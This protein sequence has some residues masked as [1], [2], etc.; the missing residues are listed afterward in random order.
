MYTMYVY[1]NYNIYLMYKT[2]DDP[3]YMHVDHKTKCYCLQT[4][5]KALKYRRNHR[6]ALYRC[7]P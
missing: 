4:F 6:C 3:Y 2:L 7:T 1:D 5:H